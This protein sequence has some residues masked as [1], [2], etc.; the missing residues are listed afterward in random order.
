MSSATIAELDEVF[1]RPKFNKYISEELRLEFLA[2]LIREAELVE[3][4]AVIVDCRDEK[5]NK[6]LELG[7]SGKASHIVTGDDDLL[8]L[9]PYRGCNN[10]LTPRDFLTTI[11]PPEST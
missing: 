9:H 5:D 3:V 10:I 7:A 2:G 1:R 11:A 6:F 4:T 8:V